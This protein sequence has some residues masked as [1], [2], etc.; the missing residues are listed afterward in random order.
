[1]RVLVT[2]DD[3]VT[4]PGLAALTRALVKW[5]DVAAASGGPRHEIVV[6]APSSNF[7]GAGA[8]VGSVSDGTKILYHRAKVSGAEG[9]EASTPHRPY[10]SSP[11]RW[12]PSVP[13]RTWCSR[14]SITA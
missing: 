12:A 8:A 4:A 13:S 7:S 9:V 3:G 11:A 1:V 10:R 2:N 5:A 14:A 6:V